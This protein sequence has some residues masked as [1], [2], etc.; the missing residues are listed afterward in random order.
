MNCQVGYDLLFIYLNGGCGAASHRQE[1]TTTP[2]SHS[3]NKSTLTIIKK[4]GDTNPSQGQL[5]KI[6]VSTLGGS[7]NPPSDFEGRTTETGGQRQVTHCRAVRQTF[8]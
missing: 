1:Q 5:V 3:A 4:M 7:T 6:V 2:V 8:R